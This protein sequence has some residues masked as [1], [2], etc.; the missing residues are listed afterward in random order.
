MFKR[1]QLILK[2]RGSDILVTTDHKIS[3]PIEYM[4]K[5]AIYLSKSVNNKSFAEGL[6][7]KIGK[8]AW[9]ADFGVGDRISIESWIHK[10]AY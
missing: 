2:L 3:V 8:D 1:E 10:T 4:K 6:T 7:D 9:I 5:D